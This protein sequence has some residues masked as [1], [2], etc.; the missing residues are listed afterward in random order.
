MKPE[1]MCSDPLPLTLT[2]I[3]TLILTRALT[4]IRTLLFF[5]PI[6]FPLLL[7]FFS[8]YIV[9]FFARHVIVDN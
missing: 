5:A 8:D 7:S 1:T 2:L 6:L 9:F 4:L 3:V